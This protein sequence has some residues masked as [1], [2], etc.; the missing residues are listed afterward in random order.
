MTNIVEHAA[1][2][3][4]S[5]AAVMMVR[6][7]AGLAA[8]MFIAGCRADTPPQS[9]AALASLRQQLETVRVC[10]PLLSGSLPIEF[11]ADAL[12]TPGV[13]ALVGAG[14]VR[15]V[16]LP[17]PLN[18]RRRVRIE[19]V[20]ETGGD[21]RLYRIGPDSPPQPQ[22]CFGRKQ[23]TTMQHE[24]TGKRSGALHYAYRVVDAP[25][26]TARPDIRA[27]F[28]FMAAMLEGDNK[29]E[30]PTDLGADG[31]WRLLGNPETN[32]L[33]SDVKNKGFFPCKEVGRDVESACR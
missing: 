13:D 12:A 20:Q 11:S 3:A 21:A 28:P 24:A 4:R 1:P 10:A 2:R 15:R 29:A 26:W 17:N 33:E 22:L 23:V 16:P 27:A 8:L 25:A 18:E 19:I 5:R 9:P 6:G 30:G 31:A 32:S 14:I 7:M